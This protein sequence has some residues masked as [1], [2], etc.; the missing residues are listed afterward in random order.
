MTGHKR[1]RIRQIRNEINVVSWSFLVLA[2]VLAVVGWLLQN[3]AFPKSGSSPFANVSATVY[4]SSS[5]ARVLLQS[6][7]QPNSTRDDTLDITV[8]EPKG[9][10]TPWVLVVTCPHYV[11]GQVP[12]ELQG[13]A[14]QPPIEVLASVYGVSH[15]TVPIGCFPPPRGNAQA[16][17]K[18]VATGQDVNL[19]LPVLE[20]SPLAQSSAATTPLYVVRSTSGKQRIERLVE[21]L[22]APGSSC[23]TPGSTYATPSGSSASCF[24]NLP[25]GAAATQ[26]KIPQSVTTAETLTS[27]SL[28]GDRIDSM[29]PPGQITSND[30][31]IWQGTSGLSPSLSATNLS[32]AE[33]SSKAGFLAGLLYGLAAGLFIPFLQ[34]VSQA[35]KATRSPREAAQEEAATGR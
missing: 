12:L 8:K 23:P 1:Q 5:K 2:I 7:I 35:V 31:I 20:Q 34:D 4:T 18:V 30:E 28:S 14:G 24:T 26:Y 16:A 13:V 15:K 19:S 25:Q 22:E 29:F 27:V 33:N 32:S 21:V 6:T 11:R 10:N 17:S 3:K 9:V